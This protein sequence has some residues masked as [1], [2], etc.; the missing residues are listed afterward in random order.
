MTKKEMYIEF[1]N[2]PHSLEN[3]FLEIVTLSESGLCQKKIAEH[4]KRKI[5]WE[6]GQCRELFFYTGFNDIK[7]LRMD[8]IFNGVIKCVTTNMP[9]HGNTEKLKHALHQ[10]ALKETDK[11]WKEE[12]KK[13][14][15]IEQTNCVIYKGTM[16]E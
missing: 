2:C 13:Y 6:K 9:S 8:L 12:Q 11:Q 10:I 1:F 14:K 5:D 15:G 7:E 3:H 16:E 4:F